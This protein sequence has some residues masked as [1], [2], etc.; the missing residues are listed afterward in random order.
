MIRSLFGEHRIV[1]SGLY[2]THPVQIVDVDSLELLLG[3][4][5]FR[6]GAVRR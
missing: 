6:I 3:G 5:Q 2:R 4:G 1:K